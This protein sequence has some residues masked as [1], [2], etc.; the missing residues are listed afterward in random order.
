MAER[1]RRPGRQPTYGIGH[2]EAELATSEHGDVYAAPGPRMVYTGA[3]PP[4]EEGWVDVDKRPPTASERFYGRRVDTGDAV[5]EWNELGGACEREPRTVPDESCIFNDKQRDRYTTDF[6]D[7]VGRALGA[8]QTALSAERVDLLIQKDEEVSVIGSMLLSL[9]GLHIVGHLSA[10]L[11]AAKSGALNRLATDITESS[12]ERLLRSISDQ[13]IQS[14]TAI[15]FE[16]VKSKLGKPASKPADTSNMDSATDKQQ[17]LSFIGELQREAGVAFRRFEG[18]VLLSSDADL[19]VGWMAMQTGHHDPETY[20]QLVHEKVQEFKKS[21]VMDIGHKAVFDRRHEGTLHVDTRVVY[22]KQM[23]GPRLWYEKQNTVDAGFGNDQTSW[24]GG[25]NRKLDRPVPEEFVGVAL[26]RSQA[27][28][29]SV[30]TIEDPAVTFM[31]QHGYDPRAPKSL[32]ANSVFAADSGAVAP[33]LAPLSVPSN[34]VFSA[35]HPAR[36]DALSE[37]ADVDPL[38]PFRKVKI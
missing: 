27:R 5:Q 26:A 17:I 25:F 9:A 30:E 12:R 11:A 20:K 34:S 2:D 24:A 37:P 14:W 23:G 3:I 6:K 33:T 13:R 4:V 38:A 31:Q 22:V 35:N 7:L 18:E 36:T 15:A 8:Y 32:P 10:A 21:G 29:G 1:E 19:F 16:P 28:W